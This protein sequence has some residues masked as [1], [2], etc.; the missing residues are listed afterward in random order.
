MR[1]KNG[2]QSA[3]SRKEPSLQVCFLID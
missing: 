3:K 2:K 1:K